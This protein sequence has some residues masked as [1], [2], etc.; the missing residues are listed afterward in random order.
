MNFVGGIPMEYNFKFLSSLE[1]VFFDLPQ[2]IPE[3][4]S[5][6]MLKNEIY[7]FQL[8][9]CISGYSIA[10]LMAK[11][12]V[13]SP[14]AE[15]ITV[16]RVDYVPVTTPTIPSRSDEYYITKTPGMF[17]DP[18]QK[19]YDGN[20]FILDDQARSF[21]VTVE[22]KDLKPGKY[23]IHFKIEKATG[24]QIVLCDKT[25]TL[26]ILGAE[27]PP[28]DIYNT[29]WFHGDCIAALHNVEIQSEE[30]L[31]LVRKY[32]DV[33]VKFG[34]NT[35][36]TP[37]FTP[38]LDTVV[39]G[40]RPTNQLIDV[41]VENGQYRFGFDK[42]K[43][44]LDVAHE[45]GV[46]YFEIAHLFTQW[47]AGH[48]PKI[49]ATVDGEYKKIFGWETDALSDEYKGFMDAMLPQLVAFLKAE[50]VYDNCWFHISDEPRPNHT[51][52]YEASQKLVLPHIPREKLLDALS[53]YEFYEKGIVAS[54]VVSANHMRNFT[55]NGVLKQWVYYCG[56]QCS[57]SPNRFMAM[58]AYRNRILG[59]QLYKYETPGFLQ[60]GY[61]FWFEQFSVGVVNPYADTCAAG[62]FPGGD[63]FLVYPVDKDGD[64]VLS[65]RLYVFNEGF[66]DL[67]AMKLLESLTDRKTVEALLVDLDGFDI[68]P[69]SNDYILD[70]RAKVNDLIREKIS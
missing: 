35:L 40:E 44:W 22:G 34:H 41:W 67:R 58:P 15:Y 6:T 47:G 26:E 4:E 18:L 5:G 66:Q 65:T 10:K 3:L 7:S 8:A 31:V 32:L 16:K 37:I 11:L 19:I 33:Y 24:D 38:P 14:L 60:W 56:S 28:L 39:G 30:Y 69:R 13:E 27:L 51:E 68:Y 70:L 9:G 2:E 1:K 61:N 53:S 52:Q 21:W 48:A 36:L 64:V 42:L 43:Q 63:S 62:S 46:R 20:I 23:P 54:P 12:T 25:F 59:S 55:D 50:G 17:P 57:Q 29:G 49:M 45:A